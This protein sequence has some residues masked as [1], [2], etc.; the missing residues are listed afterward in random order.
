MPVHPLTCMARASSHVYGTC[1]LSRV[2]R[3]ARQGFLEVE[4]PMMNMIP[5][6]ATA[7]PFITHHNDL[8]RDLYMRVAPELYLKMLVVGGLDR[9]Y[10]IGRLFRNEG[11]DQ[12]HNPEFTTCVPLRASECELHASDAQGM[13]QTHSP[14]LT[15]CQLPSHARAEHASPGV[16][17]PMA[18]VRAPLRPLVAARAAFSAV[19]AVHL[20]CISADISVVHLGFLLLR[21][22]HALEAEHVGEQQQ[23]HRHLALLTQVEPFLQLRDTPISGHQ[24]LPR[25]SPLPNSLPQPAAGWR[26]IGGGPSC[27]S[28]RFCSF[29]RPA[30]GS[31]R[32]RSA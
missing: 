31:P 12:T 4:T 8:G 2:W 29:S 18:V 20:G 22:P 24:R 28:D 16:R 1:I 30:N 27:S 13:D 9:V 32:A 25:C 19:S 10:E 5:G 17:C 6:G 11:M 14:E 23:R 21:G 15:T 7:K 3:A 26:L